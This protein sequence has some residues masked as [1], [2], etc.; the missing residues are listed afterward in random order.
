MALSSKPA[1]PGRPA[2]LSLRPSYRIG[3]PE[4]RA[5]VSEPRWRQ[6]PP[7]LD[8]GM[9]LSGPSSPMRRGS[10]TRAAGPPSEPGFVLR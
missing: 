10:E 5:A 2:P 9:T 8:C 7:P 4:T 6:K 3:N 1:A